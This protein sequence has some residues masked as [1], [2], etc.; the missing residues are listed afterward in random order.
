MRDAIRLSDDGVLVRAWLAFLLSHVSKTAMAPE[1]NA[2]PPHLHATVPSPQLARALAIVEKARRRPRDLKRDQTLARVVEQLVAART[3]VH[4]TQDEVAERMWTTASAISRL[5][6]GR[7]TR[8]TL[9]TLEKYA[10][11]VGCRLDVRLI[12]NP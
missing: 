11:A 10:L 2:P 12:S 7:H 6:A 8:P 3:R 5:E 9:S 1:K 4:M